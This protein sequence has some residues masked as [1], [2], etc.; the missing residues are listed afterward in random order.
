MLSTWGKD[1]HPNDSKQVGST[2]NHGAK[3]GG[4]DCA[5]K[6][7][8]LPNASKLLPALL[9]LSLGL[10]VSIDANA[11]SSETRI[12]TCNKEADLEKRIRCL[13]T[14]VHEDTLIALKDTAVSIW[15]NDSSRQR[16]NPFSKKGDILFDQAA[17][18]AAKIAQTLDAHPLFTMLGQFDRASKKF[19]LRAMRHAL[20]QSSDKPW[21]S[22][23]TSACLN[24][25]GAGSFDIRSEAA[26]CV[27]NSKIHAHVRSMTRLFVITR[28]T[29][30]RR[31]I[32]Q[33]IDRLAGTNTISGRFLKPMSDAVVKGYASP[34]PEKVHL[35]GEL[36]G[37]LSRH[38]ANP[39]TPWV[40]R[41]ARTAL[42][43]IVTDNANA[44][45]QCRKLRPF[46]R[47]ARAH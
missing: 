1:P 18:A 20:A 32:L 43:E 29:N 46:V 9:T 30:A 39:Q 12:E 10:V 47:S 16:G 31:T 13:G 37:F 44:V 6:W 19:A 8:M 21:R 36:C 26:Q 45:K 14:V 23:M 40:Q 27:G 41:Y 25:F 24:Q 42:Q 34:S 28:S 11:E 5:Q 33:A 22:T 35:V 2:G 38:V 7:H 17:R 3:H 15:K 4:I